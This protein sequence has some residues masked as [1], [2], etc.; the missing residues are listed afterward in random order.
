MELF[1]V[2]IGEYSEKDVQEASRAFTGWGIRR[3]PN[4]FPR[5]RGTFLFT[6]RLHDSDLKTIRGRT[7]AFS[8]EQVIEMLCED[9]ATHRLIIRKLW[10][11][12]VYPNPEPDLIERFAS[13]WRTQNLE[14]KPLLRSIMLSPEFRSDRAKRKVFK[15]PIDFCLPILRQLGVGESLAAQVRNRQNFAENPRRGALMLPAHLLRQTTKNMG[16]ELLWPPDVA[17]W[18]KGASWISSATMLERAKF[19]DRVWGT[20]VG[21][22]RAPGNRSLELRLTPREVLG[23]VSNGEQLAD[24]LIEIFDAPVTPGQREQLVSA[25]MAEMGSSREPGPT[26]RAAHSV[27]RLIFVA[28]EFQMN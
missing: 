27:S 4:G 20:P 9:P 2:G 10:E 24:A 17:G 1:T 16:M 5:P 13:E 14:L 11:W 22:P 21:T 8:G 12:F 25:A 26:L 19:A 6:R 7:G 18:E 28:P 3:I 15:N 23:T